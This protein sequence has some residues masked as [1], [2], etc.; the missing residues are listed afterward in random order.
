MQEFN[1]YFTN[2]INKIPVDVPKDIKYISDWDSFSLPP[3]HSIIDKTI[4]GCGFTEYCLR[5]SFPVILC[6]P[7]KALLENKEQQHNYK[8]DKKTGELI[9][10]PDAEFPVYY[11]RNDIEELLDY[12]SA[13]SGA[14]DKKKLT[15][16]ERKEYLAMI[17][18]KML[19]WIS[20]YSLKCRIKYHREPNPK[21]IVTYDSLHHV[22]EAL[23]KD[24][25]KYNIVVDEF[26]SIFIDAMFKS[27][28]EL[29][30]VELLKTMPDQNV[31]YIS[32]TPMMDRY[33]SAIDYFPQLP[34][35][36]FNWGDRVETISIERHRTRS[37]VTS[38]VDLIKSYKSGFYII[39]VDKDRN[40][41]ESKEIVFYVNSVKTICDIIR[42][43]ELTP[44]ECNIIC[45]HATQN[46]KKIKK[47]GR[48]FGYGKIPTKGQANKMFTFCTRTAYLG[49]D[50]YSTCAYTVVCSDINVKTLNVDIALDLPQIVGRQRLEENIFRDEVLFLY[51]AKNKDSEEI[52]VE[53]FM[54]EDRK[55][56]A[57]TS[58]LL[59]TAS[60]AQAWVKK[61][62]RDKEIYIHDYV[63][64]H[65]DGTPEYNYLIKI[66]YIR[67]YEISRRD[68]QESVLVRRDLEDVPASL[69]FNT[70]D[71]LNPVVQ[72]FI[73][74]FK[75]EFRKDNNFERKMKLVC[76][77]YETDQEK[78]DTIKN[79]VPINY[80]NY[81][82]LFG[83]TKIKSISY[84]EAD[85]RGM[86]RSSR[87][88]NSLKTELTKRFSPGSK[89]SLSEIKTTLAEIYEE[90]DITNSPKATDLMNYFEVRECKLV[91]DKDSGK[92]GRGY[93][94]IKIKEE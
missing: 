65:H 28:I 29:D 24:I 87:G 39:K 6:S 77:I 76:S 32:A 7:R 18:A 84:H 19:S 42:K 61:G 33:L 25:Y 69:E 70:R 8:K 66:G 37:L 17:K 14:L 79:L 10:D 3:G 89:F 72:D 93:E 46:K 31:T 41:R 27:N 67:G 80:R 54:E 63:G 90:L 2:T 88:M 47:L 50:F 53:E 15:E 36:K 73:N 83:P 45:A 34:Y 59:S 56:E 78:Y 43:A 23:G 74:N 21:I 12:D 91:I 60:I 11:F 9:L 52:T 68:Y 44:D 58:E 5:S 57:E 94:I 55:R 81:I 92:R 13:G 20:D 48:G 51:V 71:Y 62:S 22:I 26:Q 40:I 38:C 75:E 1:K 16:E 64:F 4:C 82:N 35:Y 30:F 86:I 85:L 49:A